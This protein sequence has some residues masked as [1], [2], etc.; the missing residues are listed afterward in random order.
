MTSTSHNCCK[1]L[2]SEP[3]KT[4][5]LSHFLVRPV[6]QLLVCLMLWA[7]A[8]VHAHD[9]PAD[10]RLS[11]LARVEGQSLVLLIRAPMSAMREADIPLVGSYL[12]MQRAG[13]ALEVAAQ[14]WFVDRIKVTTADG[15][16]ATPT[17][18]HVRVSLASDTA[19]NAW[20]SATQHMHA[21]PLQDRDLV[22]QQQFLDARLV[23]ALPANGAQLSI[24]FDAGKLGGHV[25]NHFRYLDE[26]GNERSLLLKGDAG[27][28][29][30]NPSSWP[31]IQRFVMDGISHILSG[32]DHLLFVA[33]L[34]L[35]IQSLRSLLWTVTGFTVAH[36]ITLCLAALGYTP[37]GLW[38]APAVEWAIAA[39]ILWAVV[40]VLVWPSRP[41]R[42]LLASAMGL[43]HGMGLSFALRE[44][45]P[46]AGQHVGLALASFNAGVEL[47]QVL[48]LL[49][50]WPLLLWLRQHPRQDMLRYLLC[51]LIAHTAWHWMAERWETLDKFI[52]AGVLEQVAMSSMNSPWLWLGLML[53]AV[54]MLWK[55]RATPSD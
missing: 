5:G 37:Q 44:A 14:L 24:D 33:C 4:L 8:H 54:W 49:V 15:Q 29:A 18:T 22:W 36:S 1:Q 55:N 23:Y 50:L 32:L 13:P 30:L 16:S 35:G 51:A 19:F 38:F 43:V 40:D 47:G 17:L 46:F 21:P 39:S 11:S 2:K 45:L 3:M 52:Q 27:P 31:T 34:V 41:Q 48:V 25:L 10:V 12:D 9:I 7:V 53:L 26:Q 42:W 6:T 20:E 28:V